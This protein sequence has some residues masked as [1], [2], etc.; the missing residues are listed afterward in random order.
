MIKGKAEKGRKR[1]KKAENR[2]SGMRDS[3]CEKGQKIKAIKCRC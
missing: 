2:R 1:Q 3:G